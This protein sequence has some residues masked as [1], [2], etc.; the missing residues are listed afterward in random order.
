MVRHE[1]RNNLVCCCMFDMSE[2]KG[3]ALETYNFVA[4]I[5]YSQLEM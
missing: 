5:R 2:G 3:R 1:E 4:T